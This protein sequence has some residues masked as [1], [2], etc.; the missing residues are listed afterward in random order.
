MAVSTFSEDL[1]NDK[2]EARLSVRVPYRV[3]E[4]I[5][6]AAE[7]S[8]ATETQFIAQAA[9]HAAQQVIEQERIVSLSKADTAAFLDMFDNPPAPNSKLKTAAAAYKK[10]GLNL[11]GEEINSKEFEDCIFDECNVSEV[12][13]NKC[14][15]ID[16]HFS[17]C[18]LSVAMIKYTKYSGVYEFDVLKTSLRR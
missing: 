4:M 1:P 12:I 18:N 2:S 8:G 6:L 17:K 13:F 5:K 3:K 10:S 15:F 7:L 16:C 14:E 9:Y 11:S